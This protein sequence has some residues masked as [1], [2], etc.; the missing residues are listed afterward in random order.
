MGILE[1]N[2]PTR[3]DTA[4]TRRFEDLPMGFHQRVRRGYREQIQQDSE[5]WVIVDAAQTLETVAS[6][7]WRHVQK[8]L[9]QQ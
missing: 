2:T 6:R 4:D 9:V 1:E 7:V 5:H 3:Q 8:L